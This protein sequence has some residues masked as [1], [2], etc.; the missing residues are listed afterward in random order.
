MHL[1]D[2]HCHLANLNDLLP[3]KPL[4][5]EAEQHGIARFFSSAL[6]QCEVD[7]YLLNPDK[8]ISF[9]AGIHPNFDECD[10]NLDII[11]QLCMDKRIW[12][13]GEIGLDRGFPDLVWQRDV[14]TKQLDL[15][16]QFS[17]PVVLH[18][19]GHTTEA[20][21][22]LKH[23]PLTYLVHGYAGSLEGF[24]ALCLPNTFFTISSR[25]LKPDKLPLLKA[26][27]DS[28]RYLFETDI[29]QYYVRP[30]EANPLLRLNDVVN[31]TS[32][33]SGLA[34]ELLIQRQY[35]NAELLSQN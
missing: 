13:I 2:A 20:V 17:L 9:S 14:F 4:L 25:I 5:Q 16:A 3:L 30:E 27:V 26:M 11:K 28:Q 21:E 10:L 8:R 31:Q 33:L 19:V 35:A 23:Y 22:I 15:A 34:R 18:L 7:Y 24:Q 12:A 1:I 6:R 29:T 32:A